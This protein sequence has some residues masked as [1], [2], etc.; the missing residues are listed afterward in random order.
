[1]GAPRINTFSGKATLGKMIVSFKQWYHEVQCVKDHYPE[2]VVWG[3]IVRL[4]KGPV[5][6]MA[7]YKGPTASMTHILQQLTIIFGT[8]VSFDV[9]MQNFYKVT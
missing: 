4:L 9:L 1:M 7:Q 2:P 8:M 5:A 3:S 6:V